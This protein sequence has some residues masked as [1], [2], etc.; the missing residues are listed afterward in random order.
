MR[1]GKVVL[2]LVLVF[3][4]TSIAVTASEIFMVSYLERKEKKQND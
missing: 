4:V 1:V 2:G 3:V